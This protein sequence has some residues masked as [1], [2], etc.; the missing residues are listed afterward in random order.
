MP[1]ARAAVLALEP[2]LTPPAS[3]PSESVP[4]A[5]CEVVETPPEQAL[6]TVQRPRRCRSISGSRPFP[7][8]L[9]LSRLRQTV[10]APLAAL[11]RP[12]FTRAA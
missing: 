3:E 2:A 6:L 12:A 9:A 1:P 11:W 7:L 5:A 8:V 4:L 10:L